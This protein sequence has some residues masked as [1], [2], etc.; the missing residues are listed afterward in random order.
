MKK[1]YTFI[2]LALAVTTLF[3]VACNQSPNK[4]TTVKVKKRRPVNFANYVVEITT[5]KTKKGVKQADF[6]RVDS[7]IERLYARKQPGYISKESG[8]DQKGNW[9]VVVS[10]DN[11]EHANAGFDHFMTSPLSENFRKMIDTATISHKLFTVKNDQ[12]NSLKDA[13]PYVIE[14]GT[15]EVNKHVLRDS[16]EKRDNQIEA[17]YISRQT[18]YITR[19]GGVAENGERLMMIYWRT[20][21]DA[22]AAMKE[23]LQDKTVADYYK[24][25]DWK[26]VDLKRF[27]SIN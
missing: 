26:T 9:L 12:S 4:K 6:A 21:A 18:G 23:F 17:D 7:V 24:M 25:I 14:L 20:L 15:Y 3:S 22:D 16:F 19:R 27:Q 5:Y 1:A 2:L 8:I 10:W 11:N 13:K